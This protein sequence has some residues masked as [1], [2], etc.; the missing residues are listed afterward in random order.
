MCGMGIPE[1]RCVLRTLRS[2]SL[3]SLLERFF[4]KDET[5]LSRLISYVENQTPGYAKILSS[6][7]FRTGNAY[8]IG[9][10]GPPGAGKSTLVDKLSNKLVLSGKEVGI[11]AVDPTSPFTGGALLGDRIRMQDLTTRE[12][13]FIRSM[14]TRGS[15]GGLAFATREVALLLDAFGKHYILIETVGVGQVELDIVDTC[16]T[17]LV[18]L[19]PESGDSVQAMKAGLMEIADILVVNKSDREGAKRIVSELDM[20]LDV[21]RKKGEWEYPVVSTEAVNDKGVDELLD[22]I[23]E[24][25]KYITENGYLE[26]H[27]KEQIKKELKKIIELKIR[28]LIE[29][30]LDSKSIEQ[31]TEEVYSG[32]GDP[33]SAGDKIFQDLNLNLD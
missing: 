21:R 4:Q 24:H 8:R 7:Y 18:V 11:I 26:V 9:I 2:N 19:V 13:V 29:R 10:T 32:E 30:S 3:M 5:A 17:T 20:I 23:L 33:Y 12:G 15:L 14:A 1:F 25:K 16:D 28:E 6:V 27:R 31:I 22:K